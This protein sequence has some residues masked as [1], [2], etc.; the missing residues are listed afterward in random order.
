MHQ[1]IS[2]WWHKSRPPYRHELAAS[3]I[4]LW[5]AATREIEANAAA[6][7]FYDP[8]DD[9]RFLWASQWLDLAAGNRTTLCPNVTACAA[10]FFDPP[11]TP[12]HKDLAAGA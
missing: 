1:L 9:K 7:T 6:G 2:T 3:R 4:F 10:I 11:I 8:L 12:S 5:T